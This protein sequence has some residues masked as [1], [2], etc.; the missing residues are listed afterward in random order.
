MVMDSL[1]TVVR[2]VVMNGC[3]LPLPGKNK[4]R[5][6]N[7]VKALMVICMMFLMMMCFAIEDQPGSPL[8]EHKK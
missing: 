7:S 5:H 2:H 3:A 6:A 8:S 1:A 4:P